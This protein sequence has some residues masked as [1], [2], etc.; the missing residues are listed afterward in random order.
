[1]HSIAFRCA[2]SIP[3]LSTKLCALSLHVCAHLCTFSWKTCSSL[4][5]I[6]SFCCISSVQF[7]MHCLRR[8]RARIRRKERERERKYFSGR[9]S[10][11][12]SFERRFGRRTINARKLFP[13]GWSYLLKPFSRLP[14]VVAAFG[15]AQKGFLLQRTEDGLIQTVGE[16]F[17]LLLE[18]FHRSLSLS[19][20]LSLSLFLLN[21]VNE[22]A[23]FPIHFSISKRHIS[24]FQRHEATVRERGAARREQSS[25]V[26][27]WIRGWRKRT[28]RRRRREGSFSFVVA[29]HDD[30]DDDE[31]EDGRTR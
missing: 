23:F 20:S 6:A 8:H 4:F 31:E 15:G 10:V 3:W 26:V 7:C 9:R 1:M 21:E 14:D 28:K 29:S 13:K 22:V 19:F 2:T 16:V 25:R 5:T 17:E 24:F 27:G 11:E 18:R 12:S 30:D